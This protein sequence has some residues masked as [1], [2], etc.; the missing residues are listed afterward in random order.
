[1]T[2]FE[3]ASAGS[4]SPDNPLGTR[5]NWRLWRLRVLKDHVFVI[6]PSDFAAIRSWVSKFGTYVAEC[7]DASVRITIESEQEMESL[8][9]LI[10]ARRI[11]QVSRV[12]LQF[13]GRYSWI[14]N[15]AMPG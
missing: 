11:C 6:A 4:S 12:W 7:V 14:V 8:H 5:A 13:D 1:M 2:T 9:V 3:N 10:E 15:W